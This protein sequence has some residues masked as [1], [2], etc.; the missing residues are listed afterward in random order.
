[1]TDKEASDLIEAALNQVIASLEDYEEGDIL[2]DWILVA[3]TSNPEAVKG[4][5][6]PMFFSNGHMATYRARGLLSTAQVYLEYDL[7]TGQKED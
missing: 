6:Y 2:G 4:E 5:S 3:H 1:M 7:V